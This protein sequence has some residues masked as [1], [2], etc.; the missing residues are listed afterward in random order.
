MQK[1]RSI[2][3]EFELLESICSNARFSNVCK[4]DQALMANYQNSE[5]MVVS[6]A[7]LAP[8]T[9]RTSTLIL[10][11]LECSELENVMLNSDLENGRSRHRK[12]NVF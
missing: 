5:I 4:Q 11:L 7:I 12:R 6:G 3:A 2:R 10:G 9:I 1:T 8:T